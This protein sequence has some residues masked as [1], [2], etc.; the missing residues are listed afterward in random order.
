[1]NASTHRMR[2]LL[3]A[4]QCNPDWVSV[5][6][7]GW[8]HSRA[9]ASLTD[10]HVVTHAHNRENLARAGLAEG[11]SFTAVDP[12]VADAIVRRISS[13]LG[14]P[15]GSQKGWT[16]LT[17]LSLLS[18][19]YFER[20][21]WRTFGRRIR[22]G[23]FDIVH[24]LTPLSPAIPSP[25]APRCAKVGVPFVLG[26]I[27]GGLP[28]PAGFGH[29]RAS[30]REWLSY[31]RAVHRWLPG[32]RSTR[33]A[34]AALIAGSR[35]ALAEVPPRYQGK[36]V[37]VPENA[38]DPSRFGM[39]SGTVALDP[40][41]R[42]AFVGRLVATKGVDILLE[43]A[44]PLVRA[45]KVHIDVIGDGP[46]GPA[47]RALAD[48]EGILANVDFAGWIDHRALTVRL[49]KSHVFGFPSVREFGGGVVLEAM[50]L[51]LV[52]IVLDYGGPGELVS[53]ST[54]FALPMGPRE[55][56][57]Q[58]FRGTLEHLAAN[59]SLVRSMSERARHRV[60]T[61][62]TWTVKAAQVLEIYRWILG[63]R[64]KPDFGVPLP[65][66]Q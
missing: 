39:A 55:A 4:Q 14:V 43:A 18:Y 5:P 59:P 66:V 58:R 40:P 27:N 54:G 50:A 17:A 38:I 60:H 21:V 13:L 44:A 48:R 31:V 10:A 64:E 45:G 36:A 51:G 57:V 20:Q 63:Q 42:V 30:E 24:R 16:T 12:A 32:Y 52:P 41:L 22:A 34:A 9:L 3:I 15:F 7:V 33:S 62:F 29:V 65:D 19:Y 11:S 37:Y 35:Q 8:S 2:V 53:S 1:M 47:L 56:L 23:E 61:S 49:Q 26:P 46:D 28:W 6:L 25:I